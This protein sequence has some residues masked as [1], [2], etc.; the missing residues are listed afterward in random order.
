MLFMLS[1]EQIEYLILG[2]YSGKISVYSL[3]ENLYEQ[4]AQY[5]NKGW[6]HGVGDYI[7]TNTLEEELVLNVYL[8]SAA[9]T[10]HYVLS[11][12]GL[13]IE[14]GSIIPFKQ[15]KET[16]M[17]VYNL[18]N[19]TWLETEYITAI[20][21]GESIAEWETIKAHPE[22][23]TKLKYDAVID[24]HTSDLCLSLDGII[25]DINDPFWDVYSPLNHYR[26]RCLRRQVDEDETN[27]VEVIKKVQV[28]EK[29][30]QPAFKINPAKSGK[31]YG[32]GHPYFDVPSVY[33]NLA[34]RNFDLPLPLAK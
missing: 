1:D 15:F 11:T 21:Q 14:N 7:L 2:I 34:R 6:K 5:L 10:F 33:Q 3:P 16:A 4:I 13:I 9:K 17:E 32:D 29:L 8:F 31:I 22:A 19:K 12:Q 24:E 30:I 23:G 25:K 28:A 20:G 26:C 27:E 18:Y